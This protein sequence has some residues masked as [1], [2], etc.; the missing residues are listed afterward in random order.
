MEL[1]RSAYKSI[2]DVVRNI[3][4]AAKCIKDHDLRMADH[5]LRAAEWHA[6]QAKLSIAAV[7]KS[8]RKTSQPVTHGNGPSHR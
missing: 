3:A 1:L 2:N 6:S 7:G 4:S 5:H 8:K